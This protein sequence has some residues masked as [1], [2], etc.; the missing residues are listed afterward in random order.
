MW[1]IEGFYPKNPFAK[2]ATLFSL[3]SKISSKTKTNKQTMLIA[4]LSIS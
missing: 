4:T 1:Q 3:T 2:V